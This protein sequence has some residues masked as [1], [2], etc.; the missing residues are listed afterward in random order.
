[1]IDAA[2]VVIWSADVDEETLDTLLTP[3]FPI[4]L[5]KLDRSGLTRMGVAKISE[6]QER[7]FKVFA[8]AKIIE[9]PDKVIDVASIHLA[10]KPWMLNVMAGITSTGNFRPLT[11]PN[12]L[13]ALKRFADLCHQFGT[14]PCA[15]TVLT[16]KSRELV[17]H[18]FNKRTPGDQVLI[19]AELLLKAGFTDMVCSPQ[20]AVAIRSEFTF[21]S[22]K[23]N[24]PGIRMPGTPKDDQSRTMTP[25]EAI[26]AGSDRLVIGRNLT[27]GDVFENFAAITA[28]LNA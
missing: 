13:D 26:A 21:D 28:N 4:R 17:Q 23:L 10:H 9:I 27:K 22:I 8:D 24:T 20:E 12:E 2:E 1:M 3:D 18:E 25:A 11:E 14:L 5:I 16:S 15:V 7:G 6:L 19:Y